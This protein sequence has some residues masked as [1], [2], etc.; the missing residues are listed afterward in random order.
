MPKNLDI[1]A[2][3]GLPP[4]PSSSP[5]TIAALLWAREVLQQYL[6]TT[7][8]VTNPTGIEELK[9]VN[10]GGVEQ[11]LHIRGRNRDNPVLLWLHGGPGSS[12]IGCGGDA[13]LRPWEDFFTVV[14]WDQR[15][16]GKSYYPANDE[17]EPL[18]VQR[19]IDDTSALIQYLRDYLKK[20]KLFILGASWGTVLGMHMVKNHPDWLHAYI[21]VGQVVSSLDSERALY[22]RLLDHAKVQNEND[23]I[24]RLEAIMPKL[25]SDYPERE[26]S[27]VGNIEFVRRELSRLAGETFMRHLN[28]DDALPLFD[29]EKLISPHLTLTDLGHSIL[30]DKPALNRPPYT[31]ARDFLAIDLPEDIGSSFEVPIF[32]FT[33][34]HDWQTPVSLSD[35]WFQKI[36]APHKELIHF[37][38]SAHAVVNEEPGKFLVALVNKV[39][40]FAQSV[41]DKTT[42]KSELASNNA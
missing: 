38:E 20:D 15:Q 40:P 16:T 2:A 37:D 11:W 21:G 12:A 3:L 28:N 17:T 32:F 39:L 27:Y 8:A 7:Y 9:P 36:I 41:S 33:G 13:V 14:L 24:A 4:L 31:F 35:S 30:G 19:F 34:A 29:F 5:D 25:D 23:L 10:I 1:P 18:T 22:Q 26:R 42:E 6:I